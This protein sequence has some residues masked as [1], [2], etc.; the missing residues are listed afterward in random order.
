MAELVASCPR[1]RAQ[2]MT[3]DV[4]CYC[5]IGKKYQWQEIYEVFCVCRRCARSTVFI[6]ADGQVESNEQLRKHGGIE[7]YPGALNDWLRI[8]GFVNIKDLAMRPLPEHI[9]DDI[10]AVF[11]EG[12]A[13]LATNCNNAS[14][15]MFR[16]C[17]D[18]ATKAMLPVDGVNGLN[19]KIRRNLGLRLPWLFENKILPENL[20]ILADC[21]KEDGN[22]GAHQGTLTAED[23]EDLYDFT[24]SLLTRL[25]SEPEEIRLAQVRRASRRGN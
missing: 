20:H 1:C 4:K 18:L 5:L 13:C 22:D 14:G 23:S 19:S 6:L 3:F 21:V 2:H 7:K 12:V 17:I 24:F 16:L 25:Y 9:P 11:S 15:T 10:K 8:E